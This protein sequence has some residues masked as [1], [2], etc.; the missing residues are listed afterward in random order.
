MVLGRRPLE[1]RLGGGRILRH[2]LGALKQHHPE[3]V[4]G[5]RIAKIAR[6]AEPAGSLAIVG[7]D[8]RAV[9]VDFADQRHRRRVL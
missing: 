3:F 7:D 9:V 5:L 4:G 1:L 6:K 8:G 2:A